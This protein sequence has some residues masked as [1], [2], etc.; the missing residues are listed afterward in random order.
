MRRDRLP[1]DISKI[2]RME[3]REIAWARTRTHGATLGDKSSLLIGLC[4]DL[5][6]APR[7]HDDRR[8]RLHVRSGNMPCK[9]IALSWNTSG[10]SLSLA[11]ISC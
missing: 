10:F 7:V 9:R 4:H 6:R 3:R 5:I 8:K 2:I 11:T 1:S